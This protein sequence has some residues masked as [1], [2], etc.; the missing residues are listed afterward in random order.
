MILNSSCTLKSLLAQAENGRPDLAAM[1]LLAVGRAR[2]ITW[3]ARKSGKSARTLY[4]R[5]SEA[6][7]LRSSQHVGRN[8]GLNTIAGMIRHPCT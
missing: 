4:R 5:A 8:V 1:N 7:R 2:Y 3:V 6:L